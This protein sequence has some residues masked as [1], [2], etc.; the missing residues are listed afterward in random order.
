PTHVDARVRG[1]R[2]SA[3]PPLPDAEPPDRPPFPEGPA[4]SGVRCDPGPE[5]KRCHRSQD[6]RPDDSHRDS[7]D[8]RSPRNTFL[9]NTAHTTVGLPEG[10]PTVEVCPA[11]SYSPTQSPVQY[12][13]RR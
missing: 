1:R 2:R 11:T 7:T 13:R 12:H 4:A 8:Y 6:H 5:R 9:K 3:P 10:S